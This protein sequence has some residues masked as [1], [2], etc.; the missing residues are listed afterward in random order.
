MC[1][2]ESGLQHV[3]LSSFP[4]SWTSNNE[5][6]LKTRSKSTSN[7]LVYRSVRQFVGLCV[8]LSVYALVFQ[9]VAFKQNNFCFTFA[10][11][12]YHFCIIFV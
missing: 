9:A 12:L 1:E 6:D 4:A 3:T 8:S 5:N 11:F 2:V 7:T 10:S